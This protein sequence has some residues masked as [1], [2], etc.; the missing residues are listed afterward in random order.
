MIYVWT[1]IALLST[2]GFTWFVAT[3]GQGRSYVILGATI[4]LVLL[5]L[6]MM[7]T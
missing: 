2:N 3:R 4:A 5:V 6:A 7:M 1:A